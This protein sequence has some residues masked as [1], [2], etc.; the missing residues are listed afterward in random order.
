MSGGPSS[1]SVGGTSPEPSFS[2]DAATARRSTRSFIGSPLWPFT[3]SQVTSRSST[4][5]MNGSHRS[6]LA[7][8]SFFEF[9][10]PRASQPLYQPSR[11]QFTTYVE[12]LTMCTGPSIVCTARYAARI[13]MRWFVVA[14]S[15]PDAQAPPGTAQAQPPGPGFPRHAPSV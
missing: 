3:Q 4:S 12:S 7:T 1:S 6:R 11:K 15:Y 9:F 2:Y 5:S 10:Q 13:S 8:G 14:G